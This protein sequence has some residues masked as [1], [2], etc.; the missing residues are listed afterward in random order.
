MDQPVMDQTAADRTGPVWPER[1]RISWP[2]S[3]FQTLAGPPPSA[4]TMR[5]PSRLK[6]ADPATLA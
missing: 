3:A 5:V 6:A 1:E 2:V 4:V